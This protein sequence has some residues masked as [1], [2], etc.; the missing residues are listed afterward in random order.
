MHFSNRLMLVIGGTWLVA[1]I[2]SCSPEMVP[3]NPEPGSGSEELHEETAGSALGVRIPPPH[4]DDVEPPITSGAAYF[5]DWVWRSG[6][7]WR[8]Y[9]PLPVRSETT[10]DRNDHELVAIADVNKD[11]YDDLIWRAN[12]GS[13]SLSVWYMRDKQ[14][15]A[16]R[17]IGELPDDFWSVR[18][19]GDMDGD[20]EIDL[21][22]RHRGGHNAIWF[23]RNGVVEGQVSIG[24]VGEQWNLSAVVD[25]DG[26]GQRDFVWYYPAT[27]HVSVWKLRSAGAKKPPQWLSSTDIAGPGPEWTLAGAASVARNGRA[28]LLWR[29]HPDGM[30]V[31]WRMNGGSAPGMAWAISTGAPDTGLVGTIRRRA[32]EKNQ[33]VKAVNNLGEPALAQLGIDRWRYIADRGDIIAVAEDSNGKELYAVHLP[34]SGSNAIKIIERSAGGQQSFE[35]DAAVR[36]EFLRTRFVSLVSGETISDATKVALAASAYFSTGRDVHTQQPKPSALTLDVSQIAQAVAPTTGRPCTP[37]LQFAAHA[38]YASLA[39]AGCFGAI[40]AAATYLGAAAAVAACGGLIKSLC[41]A[42]DA[43]LELQCCRRQTMLPIA[44]PIRATCGLL[45]DDFPPADACKCP[46]GNNFLKREADRYSGAIGTVRYDCSPD[47]FFTAYRFFSEPQ[48]TCGGNR[49]C[50]QGS[51][52]DQ[53]GLGAYTAEP[54]ITGSADVYLHSGAT[55]SPSWTCGGRPNTKVYNTV[56]GPAI[57]GRNSRCTACTANQPCTA[58]V[59]DLE[60]KGRRVDVWGPQ[61]FF[62][63]GGLGVY[64]RQVR[65]EIDLAPGWAYAP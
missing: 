32:F 50:I 33:E 47:A 21:V 14:M 45:G 7:V 59:P 10:F 25:Y 55:S 65:S 3:G 38:L 42:L 43:V 30:V 6:P 18:G 48:L 19:A 61:P 44:S 15:L 60:L 35:E 22:F 39:G 53:L 40:K 52:N 16:E 20:G 51:Y 28:D 46:P 17:H 58:V 27:R 24:S 1:A 8:T 9:G 31:A 62:C 64:E 13:R 2:P 34:P 63:V 29:R 5:E 23:L 56:Q 41:G 54:R 36:D 4:A 37:V 11:G 49:Q 26:D 12:F 57:C